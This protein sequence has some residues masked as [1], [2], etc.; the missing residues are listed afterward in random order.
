MSTP[1]SQYFPQ[2]KPSLIAAIAV[3]VA[4]AVIT[5]IHFAQIIRNRTFYFIPFALGGVCEIVG[6][7]GRSI[8][9][10]EYP[11]CS[12]LPYILNTIFPL[13]APAQ[14]S[15]A[16][17]MV[18]GHIVQKTGREELALVRASWRTK[19]FLLG[20][21]LSG[22]AQAIGGIMLSK[23]SSKSEVERGE[24]FISI[25]LIIQLAFFSLFLVVSAHYDFQLRN[26][27]TDASWIF[28]WQT[29]LG[30][31][32]FSG[33]LILLRTIFRVIEYIQGDDGELRSSEVYIYLFDAALMLAAMLVFNFK[34]PSSLVVEIRGLGPENAEATE[35]NVFLIPERGIKMNSVGE[36]HVAS[37]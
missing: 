19:I 15:A 4:F 5:V 16:M 1:T 18:L 27:P 11:D 17:Y 29:H 21:V 6:Y 36:R 22:V 7:I 34:H 26:N 3:I 32:Y 28:D 9:A 37:S 20:D 12:K 14:F 10:A 8:A 2:Y 31:L 30:V 33:G 25:G 24:S 23:A 13:M 35:S